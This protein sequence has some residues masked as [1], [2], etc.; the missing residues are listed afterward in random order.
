MTQ[1][2][3][4]APNA[5]LT[6]KGSPSGEPQHDSRY[7]PSRAGALLGSAWARVVPCGPTKSRH[8]VVL[9]PH[10][11]NLGHMQDQGRVFPVRRAAVLGAGTMGAQIAALFA[12]AGVPVDLLDIVPDKREPRAS[13]S[14]LAENALQRLAEQKPA[15]LMHRSAHDLIAP[16][17]LEDDLPRLAKADWIIEAVVE[18]L[19]VKQ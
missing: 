17:N 4:S 19:A 6:C 14:V 2:L 11:D 7:R 16:G 15:P 5:R 9:V 1:P 3:A 10:T 12:S 8:Q 13:R 18:D